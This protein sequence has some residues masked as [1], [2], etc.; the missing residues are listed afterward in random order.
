M[1]EIVHRMGHRDIFLL[2]ITGGCAGILNYFFSYAF[3]VVSLVA[4]LCIFV[5]RNYPRDESWFLVRLIMI[6]F[7][8]LTFLSMLGHMLGPITNEFH[9]PSSFPSRFLFGDAE[10]IHRNAYNISMLAHDKLANI[11]QLTP[12][13]VITPGFGQSVYLYLVAFLYYLFQPDCLLASLVNILLLNM[14]G[15]LIYS[16]CAKIFSKYIARINILLFLFFPSIVLWAISGLKDTTI[17]FLSLLLVYNILVFH[18]GAKFF[19]VL[20]AIVI[21]VAVFLINFSRHHLGALLMVSI[22][23]AITFIR[24]NHKPYKR[25]IY[26]ASSL[27]AILLI[28]SCARPLKS[29]MNKFYRQAYHVHLGIV[30]D[31][32]GFIY[33]LLPEKFYKYPVTEYPKAGDYFTMSIKGIFYFIASPFPFFVKSRTIYAATILILFWYAILAFSAYGMVISL[34]KRF[35]ESLPLFVPALLIAFIYGIH[36]GNYGTV[37]RH[38]DMLTPFCLFFASVGIYYFFLNKTNKMTNKENDKGIA[39]Y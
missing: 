11:V 23:V 30:I 25:K 22:I 20:R 39:S 17:I 9:A 2:I 19:F 34:W 21:S 5:Y 36:S 14:S 4:G 15:V 32:R 33:K 13:K 16:I 28:I 31:N 3:F 29:V 7:F 10:W 18:K 12:D 27:A 35:P 8:S 1:K 38:R 24:L 37:F 6:N 26:V